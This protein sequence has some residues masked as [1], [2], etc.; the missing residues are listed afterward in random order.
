[1]VTCRPDTSFPVMELSQYSI[2]PTK[3]H[4]EA[5]KNVFCYLAIT[6]N[7][8]LTYWR[9]SDNKSFPTIPH[10]G[11][12]SSYDSI[13]KDIYALVPGIP[14]PFFVFTGSSFLFNYLVF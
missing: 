14:G 12:K 8:G 13:A 4:F 2:N 11:P 9:S 6:I 1:M 3:L 5:V 10:L 7:E